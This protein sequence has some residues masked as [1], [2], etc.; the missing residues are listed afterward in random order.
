[1]A[2][3]LQPIQFILTLLPADK[4]LLSLGTEIIVDELSLS[5]ATGIDNAIG[6]SFG[7]D[8][9]K[10]SES[11]QRIYNYSFEPDECRQY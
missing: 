6:A 3:L 2:V 7:F 4:R 10:L 1:M 5:P 9:P 8:R 11:V